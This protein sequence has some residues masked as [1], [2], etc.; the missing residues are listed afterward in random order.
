M[1][2]KQILLIISIFLFSANL[3]SVKLVK[4]FSTPGIFP[5]GATYDGKNIWISDRKDDKIFCMNPENGEIIRYIE[6]PAYWPMG[7]A[8]DGKNLWNIDIKGGIPL[9]ENY[10]AK[11]YKLDPE[12][13]TIVH[14][15]DAPSKNAEGLCWDGKYL[16]CTDNINK[17]LIQFDQNDGTTI[18]SINSP[19][20]NSNGLAFDGK[21]LWVSDR[22]TNKI[23]AVDPSSECVVI[24]LDSPG[25]YSSGLCFD[26]KNIWNIDYQDKKIHCIETANIEKFITNNEKRG[27]LTYTHLT[28][29]FGP[30]TVKSLDVYFAVPIDRVSQKINKQVVFYPENANEK[31]ITDKWNQKVAHYHLE[32]LKSNESYEVQMKIDVTCYSVRYYIFPDKV[33]TIS[34]IPDEIKKK[35]LENNEKYQYDDPIVQKAVKDAVGEEKNPYWIAR[36]IFNYLINNMY[37]EMTGGWNTAPT[38]ID[39][40]NGSCS[41]YSFAYISMCRAAGLPARYVGSVVMRG[42]DTSMDDVFHRWVEVYLPNYGWIPVDPSG[43]DQKWPADQANSFGSLSNRFCITTESGGNSEYLKWTYN[44]NEFY[45]SDPKTNVVSEY[46]GDWEPYE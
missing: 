10:N 45:T 43:G 23:Y 9:A 29:N 17:K 34:E 11:I 7:L 12:D 30:G 14:C 41:E 35:Y 4:S 18:K 15:V 28:T 2:I 6:S 40:G 38:V 46:F 26:G 32:N 37:Y 13:G 21:Y 20:S 16:W 36:K 27:I 25:A 5:T 19:H 3:L 42:D 33:G 8:W 31:I 44:S 24:T 22:V 1:K 39:R